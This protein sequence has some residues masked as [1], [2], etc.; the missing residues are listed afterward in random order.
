MAAASQAA[1]RREQNRWIA[2]PRGRGAWPP[3]A[4]SSSTTPTTV[5]PAPRI[6]CPPRSA[7]PSSS[8]PSTAVANGYVA[9]SGEKPTGAQACGG[10]HHGGRHDVA[11]ERR[12]EGARPEV[13]A[14]LDGR[15][16]QPAHG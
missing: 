10:D 11:D 13:E 3:Y 7:L 4:I 12:G 16:D 2:L 9:I 15:L 8:A 14:E 6:A 1:S 5:R